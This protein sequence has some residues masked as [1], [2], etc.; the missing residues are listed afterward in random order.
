M[1]NIRNP[2]YY[3]APKGI[4]DDYYI[5]GCKLVKKYDQNSKPEQ[6]RIGIDTFARAEANMNFEEI[7]ACIRF[8]LDK[9]TWRRKGQDLEDFK[10]IIAYAEFG[11]KQLEK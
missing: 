1:A 5:E 6:Y 10:K 8:N 4:L 11:I 9:Y 3:E 7:M 2:D